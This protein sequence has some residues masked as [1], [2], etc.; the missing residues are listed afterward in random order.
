MRGQPLS[1][2]S[3]T[4]IIIAVLLPILLAA[5]SQIRAVGGTAADPI[6]DFLIVPVAGDAP[7]NVTVTWDLDSSTT[8]CQIDLG[9][10]SAPH[11][12]GSCGQGSLDHTFQTPGVYK[13]TLEAEHGGQAFER[14]VTVNVTDAGDPTQNHLPTIASFNSTPAS[15][16]APLPVVLQWVA[17]D[18]DGDTLTCRLVTGDGTAPAEVQ[19]CA[20]DDSLAHT[21]QQPGSYDLR[22]TVSDGRGGSA[23]RSVTVT[24]TDAGG[25]VPTN[26][27][28][29][30]NGVSVTPSDGTAP[31]LTTIAWDVTDADGDALSCLV[32]F[33][34]GDSQF[35]DPCD[36]VDDVQHTYTAPGHYTVT[37]TV[38]DG[39][40]GSATREGSANVTVMPAVVLSTGAGLLSVD[41]EDSLLLDATTSALIGNAITA[42][43]VAWDSLSSVEIPTLDLIDELESV[44]GMAGLNAILSADITIDQLLEAIEA[45]LHGLPVTGELADLRSEVVG[46][47]GTIRLDALVDLDGISAGELAAV[48][49][50]TDL[51]VLDLV[52][53]SLQLH[54]YLHADPASPL[55]VALPIVAGF[56]VA[57]TVAATLSV[58]SPPQLLLAREGATFSGAGLRLLLDID[59]VSLDEPLVGP[60]VNTLELLLSVPLLALAGYLDVD[61]GLTDVELYLDLAPGTGTVVD[62]D[63]VADSVTLNLVPGLVEARL[64][65]LSTTDRTA[66]FDGDPLTSL[67]FAPTTIGAVNLSVLNL[68]THNEIGAVA[69]NIGAVATAGTSASS[70]ADVVINSFPGV[71]TLSASATAVGD[72]VQSLLATT[73]LSLSVGTSTGPIND[74]LTAITSLLGDLLGALTTT[75]SDVVADLPLGGVLTTVVDPAL[76]SL[77]VG[78]GE[79][80]VAGRQLV[81]P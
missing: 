39:K 21:F 16:T 81:A 30:I 24:V 51:N 28:P 50:A 7:L 1:A 37:L 27:A 69:L 14:A 70:S 62:V 77:G 44:L 78:I 20:A 68:I 71:A 67:T 32:D 36:A 31:L 43:L 38:S 12:P 46:L 48:L 60:V 42:D 10:G 26:G 49:A 23:T 25:G 56:D 57:S 65:H 75:L 76:D 17:D 13:V 8:R 40:G 61:V 34:D 18:P 6:K 2:R 41:S 59:L 33:G 22:L 63:A 5:C 54:S 53:G 55:Q 64:G 72:L 80:S 58:T 45:A 73:D 9:D 29:V 15:G 66:Y 35:V 4:T 19:D 47:S 74:L 3:F 52:L 79:I 11:T